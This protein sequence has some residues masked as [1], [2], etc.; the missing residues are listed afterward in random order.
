MKTFEGMSKAQARQAAAKIL[1]DYNTGS[2][3]LI[4]Q[5]ICRTILCL[6]AYRT[7][8]T[9]FCHVSTEKEPSTTLLLHQALADGKRLVVPKSEPNGILRMFAIERL[10]QLAV[11]RF[12][13]LEPVGGIEVTASQID[14]SVIPCVAMSICGERLGHGCG[15]YDRFLAQ[16]SNFCVAVCPADMLVSKLPVDPHDHSIPMIV[17]EKG[18]VFTSCHNERV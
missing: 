1:S 2:L 12:G 15:Y 13:I 3:S 11:G 4:G 5:K 8:H 10:S 7:A 16:Y 17:T 14:F 6:S 18:I 9:V